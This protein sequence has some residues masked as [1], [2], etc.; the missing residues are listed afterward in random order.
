MNIY[1]LIEFLQEQPDK[2]QLVLI[3]AEAGWF[4]ICAGDSQSETL[5]GE[6]YFL[7][8]PCFGHGD[9]ALDMQIPVK[10]DDFDLGD[11]LS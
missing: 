4:S 6:K 3:Q 5:E 1:E 10:G 2:E 11:Q 9:D 7:L 8:K